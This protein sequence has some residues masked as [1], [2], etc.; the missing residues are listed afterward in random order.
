VNGYGYD[1]DGDHH[2]RVHGRAY[3]YDCACV[4][5]HESSSEPTSLPPYFAIATLSSFYEAHLILDH[6][7]LYQLQLHVFCPPA[8][9][10][11]TPQ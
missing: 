1:G 5:V 3:G 11:A 7:V 2:D 4:H 8:P 6:R 9:A 10:H